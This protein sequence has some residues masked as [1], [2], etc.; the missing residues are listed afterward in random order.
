MW[1]GCTIINPSEQVPTYIHIDSFKFSN[2]PSFPNI[3]NSSRITSVVVNYNN[4]EVGRFD[5]P[6]TI[7]IIATGTGTLQLYPGIAINGQNDATSAAPFYRP[8]TSTLVAQPGKIISYQPITAYYTAVKTLCI[9]NFESTDTKFTNWP[10]NVGQR[11]M[12]AVSD[13]SLVYEGHYSG[14]I[15]LLNVGDSC[16]DSNNIAFTLP[17]N[18]AVIEFNYKSSIPFAIYLQAN[19]SNLASTGP[20]IQTAVRPSDHWQKFYLNVGD[21]NTQWKGTSY[22]LYFKA[23][24]D[25][26]QTSGRLLLDNIQL[27][28]Y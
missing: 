23:V 4:V 24:L 11:R 21:F 18:Y 7:P 15:S 14:E 17:A 8:D 19:L 9:S 28:T 6:A 10:S 25:D 20:I 22:N 27:L 26:G 3:S 12:V 16:I 1:Q 13:D 2:S 5:L